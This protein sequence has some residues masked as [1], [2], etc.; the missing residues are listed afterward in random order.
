MLSIVTLLSCGVGIHSTFLNTAIYLAYISI[1]SNVGHVRVNNTFFLN[2]IFLILFL[3]I[4]KIYIAI[5]M[6]DKYSPILMINL[7]NIVNN[8]PINTAL[9]PGPILTLIFVIFAIKLLKKFLPT[10]VLIPFIPY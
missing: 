5:K 4:I 7:N 3:S 6:F 9:K 2:G 1:I 8:N 10:K